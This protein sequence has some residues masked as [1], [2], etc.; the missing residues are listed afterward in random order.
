MTD[1]LRTIELS[2]G[3]RIVKRSNDGLRDTS[4]THGDGIPAV[5][6]YVYRPGEDCACEIARTLWEAKKYAEDNSE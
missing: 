2:G 3:W 5:A 1:A 4:R 6:W